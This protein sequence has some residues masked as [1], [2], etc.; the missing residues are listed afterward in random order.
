MKRKIYAAGVLVFTFCLVFGLGLAQAEPAKQKAGG[1]ITFTEAVASALQEFVSV[2]K[3]GS[4]KR[5]QLTGNI[6]EYTLIL[7]VGD[8]DF[9]EIGIHRVVEEKSPGVPV[10]TKRAVMLLHGDSCNFT[11]AFMATTAN[12]SF[13]VYLAEQGI[14]VWGIDLRWNSVPDITT[15]FS[16]MEDWDTSLHLKDIKLAVKLARTVRGLTGSDDG[17]IFML[18]HSRGAQFL[19]AYANE[20]S[21]LP[22]QRRD[23]KGIIPVDMVYK[24]SPDQGDLKQAALVRYQA[25]KSL[26][27]SGVYYDD[28]AKNMKIIAYLAQ[29]APDGPSPVIPGF[30]N[31]QAAQFV[32][33][34]THATYQAPLQ[35]PVPFYHYLGGTF[36]EYGL[37]A[38]LQFATQGNIIDNAFAAPNFQSLGEI[39]DGEAIMSDNIENPYDDHLGDIKIPVYYIGAAGGFGQYGAYILELLGSADKNSLIVQV[40]PSEAAALDYGHADLF[41]ADNAKGLVW[42]PI[43]SWI[44]SH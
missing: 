30:T 29:S 33:T 3:L 28:E 38:G 39:I 32:L 2:D 8:G 1:D 40:Y 36:D 9:D 24:F 17:R 26:Y 44:K 11:N 10:K 4:V 43:C 31:M 20:E 12:Q 23:L 22:E 19:F 35:P 25:Y 16:F 27:D 18:G 37:P 42:E 15:D 13:G 7:K 34:A 6:Y 21:Q 5:Q 41:W 14:D